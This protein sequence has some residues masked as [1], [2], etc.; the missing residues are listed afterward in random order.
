MLTI[1]NWF[2]IKKLPF[3]L[4]AFWLIILTISGGLF[5]FNSTQV[6]TEKLL[7]NSSLGLY[8]F[9]FFLA[10]LL[11]ILFFINEWQHKKALW[12]LLFAEILSFNFISVLPIYLLGKHANDTTKMKSQSKMIGICLG[13]VLCLQVTVY[14]NQ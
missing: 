14:V 4:L 10:T 12:F 5:A 3:F 7:M 2:S 13:L 8:L 9:L 11:K 1:K 6:G